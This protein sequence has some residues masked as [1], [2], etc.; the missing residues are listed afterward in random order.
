MIARPCFMALKSPENKDLHP[1]PQ[2]PIIDT[3][4]PFA[5]MGSGARRPLPLIG[6]GSGKVVAKVVPLCLPKQRLN[7][8]HYRT[9][10]KNRAP[11]VC[12]G[13]RARMHGIIIYSGSGVVVKKGDLYPVEIPKEKGI[14]GH[15]LG[16]YLA[17]YLG[18]C[19]GSGW[20][21]SLKSLEKG[22][23]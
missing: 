23:F 13:A 21:K 9:T 19:G 14:S 22:D 12:A 7:S 10:A 3:R 1:D 4:G 11:H 2:G 6:A 18:L 5:A 8:T 20:S 17:H 15:Y 16:H